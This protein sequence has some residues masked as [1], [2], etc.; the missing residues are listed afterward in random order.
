MRTTLI[1]FTLIFLSLNSFAQDL[2]ISNNPYDAAPDYVKQ[3]NA[4]NRERWF[5]EQRMYPNNF[6][7]D[8]AYTNS[9]NQRENLRN[10][11]GF[12]YGERNTWSN[13]G[14]T[15]GFYFTY[16]NISSRI[17]AIKYDPNNPSIIYLGA[18]YGG[19]WKSSNGGTTWTSMMNDEASLSSGSI[20]IDPANSNIVY[21]GTGEATY[22]G[23]SYYGRGLLK[24]TDGGNT[25][26]NFTSGLG[27]LS[28]FSRIVIR[29]GHSNE[30]LAA[31]GNRTS[32]GVS[33]G[34]YRSTDAGVT[35][36]AVVSGRCDDVIFSPDGSKAYAI[37]SGTGYR[38]STDGGVTFNVSTSLS[39]ST[40][41]H[42]AL[43]RTSPNIMYSAVHS[44]SSIAVFKSTDAGVTF[45]PAAPS[46]NF[47]GSQAWYDFYMHV[48]PFDP[49]YAYVGSIDIWRTTDGGT[50][51][52]NIT[53]GYSGGNVHV[54][55]QNMDF[56]PTNPNEM[57][58]T[59]DGGVWKSTDRGSNWE[60]LNST[61]T[62]TQFYRIA[63]DPSNASHIMGGTQDN[64]TQRT[65]G[66][67]N[68]SGA[69]GGDGGEV[70]FHIVDPQYIL[71]E[72]QNNGVRRSQDGGASWISATSGLTGS[73]SW[74]GPLTSHPDSAGIFYTARQSVFKTTTWGASWFAISTGTSGTIREMGLC[75][76]SPNVMFATSGSQV[77]KYTDG[78][79]TYSNVSNGIPNKTITGIY[80]H[81][82]SSNVV[83]AVQSGFGGGHIFKTTDGGS[84]WSNISGNL[85]DSPAN[86]VLFY[87]PGFAT[88]TYLI[89]MD[90]GVFMTNNNGAT[91]TELAAGL[92]NT[93]AMHLDYNEAANKL[94]IGTH[95]RGVYEINA[96]TGISN[97]LSE[98]A[99][100]YS[101]EQNY[102]NPFNPV[103]NI[104]YKI[105]D[106]GMVTLKLYNILGS[107]VETIVNQIQTTGTYSVIFDGANLTSGVYYYTI[108][109]AS[110]SG[111][112]F[113]DTKKLI[114]L[115]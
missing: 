88:N 100:G 11:Q 78:G 40:R 83:L 80:V 93:V 31:L 70:C 94:R 5:N 44:G 4:F 54:D 57:F 32:L 1:I 65:L 20:A 108:S 114:L 55:Q 111:N 21:Y 22:S 82:D 15:S 10:S 104:K 113:T 86:D 49:D 97:S 64:G 59:N 66:T 46:T 19:V 36:N 75:K 84:S 47:S 76:S 112:N 107:E 29:P 18:A 102:P 73:G 23:A 99:E 105:L 50:S 28:Y 96:L 101:L 7:P 87:Y 56:H 12:F 67:Q 9:L 81:P 52:Q 45:T 74:V 13:I 51:F 27:S 53:N 61:L 92:P 115:K 98:V 77:Y 95:G 69:F 3:R 34:L 43:C 41:N 85:P 62:L 110:G 90:V 8:N 60:N 2:N 72:T 33:G 38:I 68:W 106:Q 89:A 58:C 6:I 37:G 103:T 14:P 63:S 30:L 79:Y 91:W 24:S 42:I 48:N 26:T 39:P 16:G 71:G 25:W 109:V 17:T 35:W